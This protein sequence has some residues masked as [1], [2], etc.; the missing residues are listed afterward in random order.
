MGLCHALRDGALQLLQ[1]MR[2]P[3][4]DCQARYLALLRAQVSAQ[5]KA[6]SSRQAGSETRQSSSRPVDDLT[7]LR[8]RLAA[9]VA[10]RKSCQRQ[11]GLINAS[12]PTLEMQANVSLAW[13]VIGCLQDIACCCLAAMVQCAGLGKTEIGWIA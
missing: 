3:P 6:G 11:V 1:G 10:S 13:K 7:M 12:C 8:R 4:A 2:R 5:S 9:L